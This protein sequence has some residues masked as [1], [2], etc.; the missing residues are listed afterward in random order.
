MQSTYKKTHIPPPEWNS[1]NQRNRPMHALIRTPPKPKQAEQ[2]SPTP[3]HGAV[4]PV[5]RVRVRLARRNRL[6]VLLLVDSAIYHHARRAAHHDADAE[7]QEREADLREREAVRRARENV[8]E[9]GEEEEEDCECKGRV[10]RKEEDGGLGAQHVHWTGEFEDEGVFEVGARVDGRG[11]SEFARATRQDDGLVGF[12]GEEGGEEDG[13]CD[14]EHAVLGPLPG[15]VLGYE[16]ADDGAV[17]V[18]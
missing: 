8:R 17:V 6:A 4:Q 9:G 12:V 5:L 14:E 7:Y 16:A 13:E 15:L 1:P 3:N 2:D 10:Q 18:C 11:E